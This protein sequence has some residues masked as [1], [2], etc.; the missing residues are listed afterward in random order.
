[1]FSTNVYGCMEARLY[2]NDYSPG[3]M[4]NEMIYICRDILKAS[5]TCIISYTYYRATDPSFETS[6]A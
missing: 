2:V 5:Q 3:L 4:Y 6:P 1:M